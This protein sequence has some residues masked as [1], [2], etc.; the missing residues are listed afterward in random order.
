MV[1]PQTGTRAKIAFQSGEQ[2]DVLYHVYQT[3]VMVTQPLLDTIGPFLADDAGAT[4]NDF[5]DSAG[6][7]DWGPAPWS[8]S[9]TDCWMSRSLSTAIQRQV[10]I[11]TLFHF[12]PH[13][14]CSFF[15]SRTI[16]H[17]GEMVQVCFRMHR[18]THHPNIPYEQF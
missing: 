18:L 6:S 13:F 17:I 4:L 8:P 16:T 10:R 15:P 11:F 7:T 12:I 1:E 3:F 2:M 14:L 5:W 9:A